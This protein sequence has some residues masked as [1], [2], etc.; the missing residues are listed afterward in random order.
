MEKRVIFTNDIIDFFGSY[1]AAEEDARA[2]LK[3]NGTEEPTE[4][5]IYNVIYDLL[6][7]DVYYTIR[8]I[9]MCDTHMGAWLVIADV[10]TWQGRKKGGHVFTSLADA[11]RCMMENLEDFTLF[12]DEHGHVTGRGHHHD[13]TNYFDLYRLSNAGV[14]FLNN[15][16]GKLPQCELCERLAAP[17]NRRNARVL[18]MI[19]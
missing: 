17:H 6:N 7:D 2:T 9:E 19:E 18:A 12:E 16:A 1:D 13:G 5:A 10:G 4:D 15:N 8:N 11:I 14:N 3:E